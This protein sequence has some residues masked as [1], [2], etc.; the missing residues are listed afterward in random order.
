[1]V[2]LFQPA[3][4]N[5]AGAAAV[6]ADRQFESIRPDWSFAIHNMP[7]CAIGHARLAAGPANCASRGLRIV[8]SGRT[9]HASMPE[10]GVSPT[11]AAARLIGG[12]PGL[13]PGGCLDE[14]FR[15]VTLTHARIGE[16]AFGVAPG[17]AEV[18]VTLR[19]LTDDGMG[20]LTSAAEEMAGREA[21]AAGLGLTMT[22]HDVF[23]AC[24]NDAEATRHLGRALEACGIT[25]DA[26]ALPMRGSEDFGLFGSVAKSAMVFLGAG[27]DHPMV[28]NP[29]YDF[30]DQLIVPGVRLFEH[31]LR[32]LLDEGGA[33]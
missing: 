30:P 24:H 31:V 23:H 14:D 16:Q 19:T 11:M 27:E 18:W 22:Y 33:P 28:H 8:L 12:L 2:L 10:T 5:G 21:D 4:E 3:E 32:G 26:Q 7:G 15:L 6:L 17:H 29:D 9:A 13:G 25:F 20:A 1:M